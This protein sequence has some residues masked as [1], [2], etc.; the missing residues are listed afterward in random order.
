MQ[1]SQAS[2]FFVFVAICAT[3]WH[4]C[5]APPGPQITSA[6]TDPTKPVPRKSDSQGSDS[7]AASARRSSPRAEMTLVWINEVAQGTWAASIAARVRQLIEE[8][9]RRVDGNS[10]EMSRR[11]DDLY[12]KYSNVRAVTLRIDTL[13]T[14]EKRLV[15]KLDGVSGPLSSYIDTEIQSVRTAWETAIEQLKRELNT[16]IIHESNFRESKQEE[17][18]R[19]AQAAL[20][21]LKEKILGDETGGNLGELR[22]HLQNLRSAVKR[23][24]ILEEGVRKI[25]DGWGG[26]KVV[27]TKLEGLKASNDRLWTL[28]V[29]MVVVLG[30]AVSFL[31]LRVEPRTASG[32]RGTKTPSPQRS[33]RDHELH[34]S[35]T[36]QSPGVAKVGDE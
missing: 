27:A 7:I 21:A 15:A 28:V 18:G 8:E 2:L 24:E 10:S 25:L 36:T 23:G 6:E 19:S 1:K 9:R 20:A 30:S 26:E 5:A 35:K 29:T 14:S 13:E 32:A 17:A 3:T 4:G 12:T 22:H 16:K 34:L 31:F 11:M 33:T